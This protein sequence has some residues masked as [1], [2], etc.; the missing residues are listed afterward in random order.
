MI[1]SDHRSKE[2][3]VEK[4]NGQKQALVQTNHERARQATEE[5]VRE[6]TE[7]VRR[8]GAG[9]GSFLDKCAEAILGPNKKR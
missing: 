1:T 2:Y 6:A 4:Q 8:A 5:A 9:I 7:T 3:Q